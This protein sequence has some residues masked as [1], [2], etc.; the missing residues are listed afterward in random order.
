MPIEWYKWIENEWQHFRSTPWNVR[1]QLWASSLQVHKPIFSRHHHLHQNQLADTFFHECHNS[2]SQHKF[3]FSCFLFV[4]VPCWV[5]GFA[6]HIT[7]P[8]VCHTFINTSYSRFPNYTQ[9]NV[10]LMLNITSVT[11]LLANALPYIF[12]PYRSFNDNLK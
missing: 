4:H 12:L 8:F 9:I 5:V 11:L 1:E 6:L 10:H 3:F 2:N 7:P